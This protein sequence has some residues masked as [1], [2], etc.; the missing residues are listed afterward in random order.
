MADTLS[1][2]MNMN[3]PRP[4]R[5]LDQRTGIGAVDNIAQNQAS[6]QAWGQAEVPSKLQM[7]LR[8]ENLA[9]L[10]LAAVGAMTGNEEIQ[11][12]AAGMGVG[13]L[14]GIQES[15]A[16]GHI[17]KQ[18]QI[19]SLI[20]TIEKQQQRLTT[21]VQSQPGMFVDEEGNDFYSPEEWAQ[22]LGTGVPMSPSAMVARR[23]GN[24]MDK[25]AMEGATLLIEQ[26]MDVGNVAMVERG[27]MQM[28]GAMN[29]SFTADEIHNMALT[30]DTDSFEKMFEFFSADSVV[31]AQYA[32][33][34]S[35]V[36][37]WHPG[38]ASLLV[39]RPD[40]VLLWDD[41]KKAQYWD[42]ALKLQQWSQANPNLVQAYTFSEQVSAALGDDPVLYG[43]FTDE[44]QTSRGLQISGEEIFKSI[45]EAT[46]LV[47]KLDVYRSKM[48]SGNLTPAQREQVQR[49][50][51]MS[52][53]E[54]SALFRSV[55][56]AQGSSAIAID[57]D[58][59]IRDQLTI[60]FPDLTYQ[61]HKAVVAGVLA[62]AIEAAGGAGID[63]VDPVRF[64][65]QVDG[66]L[67][68]T[69]LEAFV[70]QLRRDEE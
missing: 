35:A 8:P 1:N 64:K 53:A 32:S 51:A 6:L 60:K 65:E 39:R 11:G 43:V 37:I 15:V 52:I 25:L 30:Y 16:A 5:T 14:Q 66:M 19:D 62:A 49:D 23:A 21:L 17:K 34:T 2:R 63:T 3:R 48:M 36:P 57:A 41:P 22:I 24:D 50:V 68:P 42:A 44:I 70:A 31:A 26:G 56:T 38:P 46:Q 69:A 40:D 61:E 18:N 4:S 9:M 55:A 13:T 27:L 28:S 45:T 20:S 33:Q 67:T 59:Q 58:R 54:S 47:Q 7:L 29:W 10:G 12:L